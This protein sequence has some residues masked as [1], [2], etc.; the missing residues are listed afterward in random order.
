VVALTGERYAVRRREALRPG[1]P[2]GPRTLIEDVDSTIVVPTGWSGRVE[3]YGH[4]V[5]EQQA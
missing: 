2:I 5:I 1:A 3:Q 4:V